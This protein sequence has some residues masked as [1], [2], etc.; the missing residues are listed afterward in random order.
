MVAAV[1]AVEMAVAAVEMVNCRNN[2]IEKEM[3]WDLH[4]HFPREKKMA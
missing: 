3:D 4:M 1:I 2:T